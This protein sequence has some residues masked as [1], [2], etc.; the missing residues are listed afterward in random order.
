MATDTRQ[1]IDQLRD[2]LRY[3]DKIKKE[4]LE[5]KKELAVFEMELNINKGSYRDTK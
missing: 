1:E 4:L 2:V 3:T 5:R